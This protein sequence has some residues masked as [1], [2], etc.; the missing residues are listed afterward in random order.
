MSSL[1]MRV[2]NLTPEATSAKIEQF[3]KRRAEEEYDWKEFTLQQMTRKF[4][5]GLLQSIEESPYPFPEALK[6]LHALKEYATTCSE[7]E[8]T[9]L[10]LQSVQNLEDARKKRGSELDQLLE[11]GRMTGTRTRTTRGHG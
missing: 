6:A 8:F 5:T 3:R 2:D 4:W 1:N 10:E 11:S 7:A 9:E